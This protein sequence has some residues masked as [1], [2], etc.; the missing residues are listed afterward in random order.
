ML[1]IKFLCISF[2]IARKWIPFNIFDDK[3]TFV[4]VMA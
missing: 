2:E 3:S 4:Q 1:R